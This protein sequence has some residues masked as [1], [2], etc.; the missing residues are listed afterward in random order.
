MKTITCFFDGACEPKNPG[1]EMGAGAYI[2]GENIGF[3]KNEY[4]AARPENTNNVA[5]YLALIMILKKLADKRKCR[6]E[7][8]G[9]SKL[10]VEQ[11]NENWKIKR[12]A[13][14]DY[15]I[16]ALSLLNALRQNN[17][18]CIDWVCR[19]NN[20]IADELSKLAITVIKT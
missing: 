10:V 13:Y 3:V 8:F 9:D 4:F 20:K 5:E 12:G 1:G 18:V 6:I 11:M 17:K 2:T 7:I 19:E 15:A 16:Q 14:K